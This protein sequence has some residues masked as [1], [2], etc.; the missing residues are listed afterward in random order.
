MAAFPAQRPPYGT[1]DPE[2]LAA[3]VHHALGIASD[4][5]LFDARGHPSPST[6]GESLTEFWN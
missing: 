4:A 5:A 6:G 2:D 3:T 1:G